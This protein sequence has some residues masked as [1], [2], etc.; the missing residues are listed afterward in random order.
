[1]RVVKPQPALANFSHTQWGS[2][3]QMCIA[4]G[5]GFRLSDPR[6]L[7]HEASVWEALRA[8]PTVVPMSEMGMPKQ[9]A[10]WLLAGHT[11]CI[12]SDTELGQVRD[13]TAQVCL[14]NT[15]K[16]ISALSKVSQGVHGHTLGSLNVDHTESIRGANLANPVGQHGASAP[17]Q[18]MT[19]LGPQSAAL[20]GLTPIDTRW[21][22]RRQWMPQFASTLEGMAEDGSHMGWPKNTDKRFFQQAAP[23]QWSADLAW[24][25]GAIYELRGFGTL[26]SGFKG[27]LPK[28]SPDVVVVRG[29]TAETVV[30]VQQTVWFLPDHDL[31]VMWWSGSVNLSHPLDDSLSMMVVALREVGASVNTTELLDYATRRTNVKVPDLS[32]QSDLPLLPALA[33]GW[34]WEQ[35][36]NADQHPRD[37]RVHL[38]YAQ[39]R[40]QI[41]EE[42]ERM[43]QAHA[44][45]LQLSHA[46]SAPALVAPPLHN[47]EDDPNAWQT[48]LSKASNQQISDETFTGQNFK[49]HDWTGWT[50]TNVR[51]VSCAMD[52]TCWTDCFFENV[53]FI[54]SS[55]DQTQ[56]R[57]V[58]WAQGAMERCKANKAKWHNTSLTHV[59]LVHCEL[60]THDVMGGKWQ[61]VLMDEVKCLSA[62]WYQVITENL[63]VMK[64]KLRCLTIRECKLDKLSILET[65]A[66]L[67]QWV[68][69][70]FSHAAF[71]EGTDL[72]GSWWQDCDCAST[73]WIGLMAQSARIEHCSFTNL[74][75]QGAHLGQTSWIFCKLN[76]AQLL[77]ADLRLA[78]F[79]STSLRGALLSGAL[80]QN[81][82]ITHSNL[83]EINT[84]NAIL[85]SPELWRNNLTGGAVMQP[86]RYE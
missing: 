74:N 7:A 8:T 28:L 53:E 17:L 34:A 19:W 36:L 15:E 68:Q 81:S 54:D 9:F 29:D 37:R 59:R 55:F 83:I 10:E 50:L 5:V 70:R 41:T 2:Q 66:S 6:V 62:S 63:V 49:G 39:L 11:Q 61:N 3:A 33:S 71:V 57:N 80:L 27:S 18:V 48:Q 60:S 67:S 31:G 26:A 16:N 1:M 84:A 45:M 51:F 13:W 44:Q 76:D 46:P 82:Q 47:A 64:S 22:E 4:I 14:A 69:S 78:S 65:D 77:N 12:F 30:L 58:A 24:T 73:C 38:S 79:N 75:A 25:Q 23:D 43:A 52:D 56:W 32:A 35:I 42:E 86:K 85:S 40:E 20:A 72:S 21:P